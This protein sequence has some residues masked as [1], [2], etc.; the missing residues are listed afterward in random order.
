MNLSPE[1]FIQLGINGLLLGGFYAAATLGFSTIWGVMRLINLAHG[2]FLLMGA[3]TAWFFFNPTREQSLNIGSVD[4]KITLIIMLVVSLLFGLAFSENQL[5]HRWITNQRARTFTAVVIAI[6]IGLLL[7]GLWS[8]ADFGTIQFSMK[9]IVMVALMLSLGFLI[10]HMLLGTVLA[11]G[12]LRTRRMFGYGLSTVITLIFFAW[13]E[14]SGFPSID[15]FL[16]LPIMFVLYFAFGYLLQSVLLNRLVEGP[17]LT[18][19]LVTFALSIAL[20][21]FG[22]TIYR[23][24]PRRINVDYG[25]AL[26]LSESLTVSPVKLITVVISMFL[27]VGLVLFLRHTRIGYAIRAAAQHK[28][29]ARLM[30]INIYETYA[31]TFGL[32]LGLTAMAG[33]MMGTFQPITPVAGPIWTLRAFA[34]VA[35]GGLGKVQGVVVGGLVLG[36]AESYIGGYVNTGWA[37]AAAFMLLVLMLVLR[38]QGITGGLVAAEE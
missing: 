19:L 21:N 9:L 27:M 35:L 23:A 31:I 14:G 1:F 8:L 13:W 29:A 38:P 17:Y 6:S 36:L 28:M 16:T 4:P 3:F 15:P 11:F 37:A 18:M 24:D 5:L 30:G 22:L 7:Y 34:I 26:R 20:Q 25:N 2:E 10:S 33:A 32:S 12:D